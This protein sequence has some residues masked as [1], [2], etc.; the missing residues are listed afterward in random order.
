MT[1]H[2]RM[3]NDEARMSASNYC[4]PTSC[5]PCVNFEQKG[6]E[7]TEEDPALCSLR[8][9]LF[10]IPGFVWMRPQAALVNGKPKATTWQPRGNAIAFGLPLNDFGVA[11]VPRQVQLATVS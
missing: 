4:L 1:K 3:T 2:E 9:L 11:A 5:L 7:T 10:M 6:T 8:F